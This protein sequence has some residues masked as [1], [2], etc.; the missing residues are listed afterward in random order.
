MAEQSSNEILAYYEKLSAIYDADRFGNSYGSY[1]HQQEVQLLSKIAFDSQ[2]NLTLN[3]GCGT[4][5]LMEFADCGIDLSKKMI[6]EATAKFPEKQ[7]LVE[8]GF[9]THFPDGSFD[10]IISFH[11]L[12]HLQREET[13]LLLQEAARLLKKGGQFIVDFPSKKRRTLTGHKVQGWHGA[14]A[15]TIQEWKIT[16]GKDWHIK[17]YY[18]TLFLPIHRTKASLRMKLIGL[19]N[20]LCNSCVK[21][22]SSYLI[23]T[24]VKK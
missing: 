18:G 6:A 14:N 10:R 7:F 8:N 22:Y 24:L 17:S 9:N 20:W 13:A 4:G 23:V 15:F 12:M 5:R 11:L 21:E 19:D 2:T 3:I 1:L 16:F